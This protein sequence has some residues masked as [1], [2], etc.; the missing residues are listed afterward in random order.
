MVNEMLPRGAEHG[1][2]PRGHTRR[3]TRVISGGALGATA[4]RAYGRIRQRGFPAAEDRAGAPRG[5]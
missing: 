2:W 5:A 4:Y 3:P 1:L